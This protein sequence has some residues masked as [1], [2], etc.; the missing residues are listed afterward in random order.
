MRHMLI[1]DPDTGDVLGL[2]ETFTKD[3][4]RFAVRAGDVREYSAWR[5]D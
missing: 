4:R 3:R 1:L 5:R 2:E